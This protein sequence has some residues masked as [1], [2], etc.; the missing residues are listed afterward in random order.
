MTG[1]GT[2]MAEGEVIFMTQSP[3]LSY[4]NNKKWRVEVTGN[5]A[6]G[7]EQAKFFAL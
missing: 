3:K 6:T 1:P 4:L 7:E 2:S 5:G